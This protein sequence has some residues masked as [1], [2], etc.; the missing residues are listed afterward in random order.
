MNRGLSRLVS[1]A[2]V[3][4]HGVPCLKC[5]RDADYSPVIIGI[6]AIHTDDP[7]NVVYV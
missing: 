6:F 5:L 1:I 2:Y 3:L 7:D 4:P